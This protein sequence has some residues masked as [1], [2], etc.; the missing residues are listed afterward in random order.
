[1]FCYIKY[2]S[3][4]I[5]CQVKNEKDLKENTLILKPF[6]MAYDRTL[7]QKIGGKY[8]KDWKVP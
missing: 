3:V 2:K 7:Y 5:F 6:I 1:M 8:R 4:F